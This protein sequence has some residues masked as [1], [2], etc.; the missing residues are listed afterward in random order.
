MN[1]YFCL[2]YT[3]IGTPLKS[4]F[5]RSLF[6]I[7]RSVG[8]FYILWQI[9]KES[10]LWHRGRQLGAEFYLDVFSFDRRGWIVLN[11]R[12]HYLIEFASRD[13]LW[14]GCYTLLQPFLSL[15]YIRCLFN[16]EINKIGTCGERFYFF[17]DSRFVLFSRI[18]FLLYQIPFIHQYHNAFAIALRQPKDIG[19]LTFKTSRSIE[20]QN[21]HIG[22]LNGANRTHH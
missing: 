17:A 21:T 5:S 2:K 14:C 9:R 22:V 10:K 11:D 19:I 16:A 15:L 18:V 20:H 4:K 12:Q 8:V 6:S 13:T 7:K 3:S 1:Y